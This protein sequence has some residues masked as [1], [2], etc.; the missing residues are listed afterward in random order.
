[1]TLIGVRLGAA[2]ALR[3]GTESELVE[4]LVLWDPVVNGIDFLNAAQDANADLERWMVDLFG[5]RPE[6]LAADGPRDLF[7][8][9]YDQQMLDEIAALDLMQ[10]SER[11]AANALILDNCFDQATQKLRDRL[12]DIGTNVE[13]EQLAAPKAWILEPHQG[14]VPY[15]SLKFLSEWLERN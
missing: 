11:P 3:A 13:L 8:F 2:L 7:G 1:M 6:S 12:V 14:M 15:K 10:T 9:R 4:C 5:R